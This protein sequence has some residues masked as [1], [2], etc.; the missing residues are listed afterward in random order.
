[1]TTEQKSAGWEVYIRL[2]GYVKPYWLIFILSVFGFIIF[3]ASQPALAQL[4]EYLVGAI[5]AE[6]RPTD[7]YLIP[8]WLVAIFLVRGI[9]S[10]IGNYCLARVS[11]GIV[12]TM[13]V[14]L[15]NGLT[16]LPGQY[17]DKHNSGHLISRITF[18]VTQVTGAATDALKI[19]IR[20]GFTV[21]G[22]MAYL[23]IKDWQLS[24][25]FLGI[26]PLIGAVVLTAGKR[27]RKIS[28][29]I[30]VSMGAITHVASEMIQGY[31]VM[32]SF[33]GEQYEKQRFHDA[34]KNHFRQSMKMVTTEAVSTPVLQWIV[35][36]AMGLLMFFA[37]TFM[38]TDNAGAFIAYI[39]A[40]ALIPK[41]L[42]QLS[43]VNSK[44]QRGIAA[45]QSIFEQ[46]DQ[47]PENDTGNV[48]IDR[49]KGR[50]EFKGVRF[51]Y[52]GED[53]EVLQDIDFTIEP[54]Q[55]VALVGRSGSGKST[56]AS[57]IPRFYHHEQGQILIDGIAI[58][59]Y[60]LASLRRQIALV[61]QDIIL[62]N[63]TVAGNIAYGDLAKN[64]LEAIKQAAQMAHAAEFIEA[65]PEGYETLIGEGG[66]R[67]SGGQR[68]RLAVA[69]ALLKDAPFLILDEATS[70]LDTES[71][72][73][74]QAALDEVI[75]GRTT[76]V[77]AHRLSTIEKADKIV[78]MEKGR[79][80]EQGTHTEL[81]ELNGYYAKL[82]AM[83]FKDIGERYEHSDTRVDDDKEGPEPIEG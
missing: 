75:R 80:V 54:G 6:N 50:V 28:Q 58:E 22:L 9:G 62:F 74:I 60:S 1:M 8:L 3:A 55:T 18:N 56:L 35:A 79:I 36:S 41:S 33:G 42:R 61:N 57:L 76:I 26:G 70:A 13:R 19:I 11:M 44:I 77:I 30:Q 72:R 27:F 21:I 29:K 69:R 48:D 45:A 17:F 63:D 51:S 78:V 73:R 81:L 15:F 43:S 59:Q 68:Q 40:A 14:E 53:E 23:F 65:F 37:L 66:L 38:D 20:E 31:R 46:L 71:E 52:N 83:Q 34:S 16:E 82:H 24:L 10:F 47:Q 7:R 4:M 25:V 5:E 12:H 64:S 39:T 67:L 49:V 32:R 2:L